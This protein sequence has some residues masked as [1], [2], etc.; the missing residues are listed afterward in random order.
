MLKTGL[1]AL[2][3]AVLMQP[4][5]A[6]EGR[7]LPELALVDS[8]GL[9]AL[10]P[11]PQQP[12]RWML[13]VLDPRVASSQS[14][15]NALARRA[16]GY[17]D[18][19]VVVVTGAAAPAQSFIASNEKLAGVRWLMDPE[20]GAGPALGLST[21]PV[22]L[23]IDDNHRIAWQLAGQPKRGTALSM[24][25]RWLQITAQPPTEH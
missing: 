14:L 11:A 20:H 22:L 21:T 3:A 18:R 25:L 7:P 4:A 10:S 6:G 2:L 23:A 17:D 8:A 24:V 13:V 9:V 1:A 15:V 5:L 16:G 12:G 19:V